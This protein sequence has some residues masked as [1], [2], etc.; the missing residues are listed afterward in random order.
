MHPNLGVMFAIRTLNPPVGLRAA[1]PPGRPVV[2]LS[3]GR[4]GPMTGGTDGFDAGGTRLRG[5]RELGHQLSLA[6]KRRPHARIGAAK[7]KQLTVAA[8]L[9]DLAIG[10]YHDPVRLGRRGEP[11]GDQQGGTSGR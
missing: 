9:G 6:G 10:Q 7:L 3:P 1:R 2:T 8:N 4:P 5:P 11:V